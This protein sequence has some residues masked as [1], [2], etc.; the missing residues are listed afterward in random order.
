MR[1]TLNQ[2]EENEEEING[3]QV[4]NVSIK[5]GLA[6]SEEKICD[7]QENT[8]SMKKQLSEL[9]EARPLVL[10]SMKTLLDQK[11]AD[12][13]SEYRSLQKKCEEENIALKEDVAKL[14]GELEKAN[15]TIVNNNVQRLCRFVQV[16]HS[17]VQAMKGKQPLNPSSLATRPPQATPRPT[18]QP[19][20]I[21]ATA[22]V[23]R[24][25]PD[26][27][28]PHDPLKRRQAALDSDTAE[29]KK[30]RIAEA[31]KCK[32]VLFRKGYRTDLLYSN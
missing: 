32:Y 17:E 23:T 6:K 9:G 14:Q 27:N 2:V 5:Q 29:V 8:E 3:L 7:L 21:P 20:P 15:S 19:F 25:L 26:T 16:L 1:E 31:A 4:E 30:A 28:K 10:E 22:P 13:I 12:I 24:S 11:A 18:Q